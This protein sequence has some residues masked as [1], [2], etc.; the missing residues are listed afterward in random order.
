M[1]AMN[2]FRACQFAISAWVIVFVV[3]AAL[4]LVPAAGDDPSKL[5]S[6]PLLLVVAL[7][8]CLGGVTNNYRRSQAPSVIKQLEEGDRF[9]K[10]LYQC[11]LSPL[12]GALFAI[13]A[14]VMFASQLVQGS[15]FPSFTD[16]SVTYTD[17][18]TFLNAVKP[19]T[20][21]DTASVIFWSIVAGFCESFVPN[22]LDEL[23]ASEV[24]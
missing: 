16:M 11:L 21:A 9:G 23:A 3:T 20:H 2:S 4:T 7:A 18:V 6:P 17:M 13:I 22:Y 14:Y 15:L 1:S 10:V 19:S 8:G 24:K 12:I 5:E